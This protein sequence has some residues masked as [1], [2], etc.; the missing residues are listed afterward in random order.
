MV[1]KLTQAADTVLGVGLGNAAPAA[2]LRTYNIAG[3]AKRLA[4]IYDLQGD[5][6]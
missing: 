3:D 5:A 2:Y 6:Q 4:A 1:F